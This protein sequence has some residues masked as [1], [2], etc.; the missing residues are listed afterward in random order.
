[1]FEV[2]PTKP[3]KY[4]AINTMTS[5]TSYSPLTQVCFSSSPRSSFRVRLAISL[6]SMRDME[7]ECVAEM[8]GARGTMVEAGAVSTLLT[9]GDF[10]GRSMLRPTMLHRGILKMC[11][12]ADSPR[13]RQKRKS[14]RTRPVGE[15]RAESKFDEEHKGACWQDQGNTRHFGEKCTLTFLTSCTARQIVV[16]DFEISACSRCVHCKR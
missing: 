13:R 2:T 5:K 10:K 7:R 8:R 1:M 3:L 4:V 12:Q 16:L 6:I 9:R 11:L 14:R 15:R